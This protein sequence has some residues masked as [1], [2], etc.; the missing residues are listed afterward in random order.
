MSRLFNLILLGLLL[1]PLLWPANALA[2][3]PS[4]PLQVT[5]APGQCHTETL[6]VT[7]PPTPAPQ[8]DVAL[9]IDVTNSMADEIESV[10]RHAD[11][12]VADVR[13]LVPSAR[14]ALGSLSD[15]PAGSWWR[16]LLG[17]PS[18][19]HD[20]PWQVEQD[21]T[22]SLAE[23]QTA[24][25]QMRLLDGGDDPESYLRALHESQALNWRPSARRV[26]ILF[27]DAAPHNPDPGPDAE[28]GTADDLTQ[29]EVLADLAAA[30]ITVLAVYSNEEHA[31]FY[32][33]VAQN[34]RGSAFLLTD[35]SQIPAAVQGLLAAT[36]TQIDHLTL[37]PQSPAHADWLKWT[38][39][40]YRQVG[41]AESRT[42]ETTFCAPETASG[43]AVDLS[44]LALAD[45]VAVQDWPILLDIEA[46]PAPSTGW[47]WWVWVLPLLILGPLVAW[48]LRRRNAPPPPIQRPAVR[49]QDG[50]PAGAPSAINSQRQHPR[51][52]EVHH[53]GD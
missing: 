1:W 23:M 27:G 6:S 52:A 22:A 9:V 30:N 24:L 48:L 40:D 8:L 28:L 2:Q 51:P 43:G 21:F 39:A 3:N 47:P 49:N 4:Q 45:G 36:I 35:A 10:T 5:L 41:P 16:A 34:T 17:R 18:R 25:N 37:A 38:P 7:T 32:S 11:Q 33:A 13:E 26:V 29:A 19:H 44:L 53:G 50:S 46:P 15:Y 42:F 14:F 12:I 31:E 20:R